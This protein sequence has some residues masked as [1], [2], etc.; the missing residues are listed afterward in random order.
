MFSRIV[1]SS[2]PRQS[3]PWTHSRSCP[4]N[5]QSNRLVGIKV[6]RDSSWLCTMHSCADIRAVLLLSPTAGDSLRYCGPSNHV[7]AP[8]AKAFRPARQRRDGDETNRRLQ[9]N[10][11]EE[12]ASSPAR[13]G[14]CFQQGNSWSRFRSLTHDAVQY[15]TI[16]YSMRISPS[17]YHACTHLSSNHNQHISLLPLATSLKKNLRKL[18]Y[19]FP[20]CHILTSKCLFAA[21]RFGDYYLF[22]DMDMDLDP[23]IKTWKSSEDDH[24][25]AKAPLLKAVRIF[26][27]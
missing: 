5:H 10:V 19:L 11:R 21:I 17:V 22:E 25:S 26:Y 16:L 20:S 2:A 18:L 4:W 12:R 23:D 15:D 14:G 6:Y 9:N 24:E 13:H 3:S 8:K 7:W 1:F 27:L